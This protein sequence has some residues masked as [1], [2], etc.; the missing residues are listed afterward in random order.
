MTHCAIF[1]SFLAKRCVKLT[2]NEDCGALVDVG[3]AHF[4]PLG[5]RIGFL[6]NILFANIVHGSDTECLAKLFEREFCGN[7]HCATL[8]GRQIKPIIREVQQIPIVGGVQLQGADKLIR[9]NGNFVSVCAH[10]LDCMFD[11]GL[12]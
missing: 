10:C 1:F 7:A 9:R 11:I 8:A 2:Y 6:R 4:A 12:W 5:N 3:K